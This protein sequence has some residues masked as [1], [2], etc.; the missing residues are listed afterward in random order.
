MD[1]V[2]STDGI[3]EKQLD[4]FKHWFKAGISR[5]LIL[6]EHPNRAIMARVSTPPVINLLPFEQNIE[7]L[8]S[9][10]PYKTK[11]TLYKG[12]IQL[13]LVM[14]SPHWYAI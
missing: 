1:F 11:T 3:D 8:I 2:L 7:V 5:E 12:D 10:N 13:S 9:G 14:D 4:N 6:A